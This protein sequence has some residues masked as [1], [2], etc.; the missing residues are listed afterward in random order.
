MACAQYKMF[1]NGQAATTQQLD[2][3]ETITVEQEMDHSWV[4][5]LEIPLCT[6][7]QGDWTGETESWLQPL[8]RLRIEL[9][10]GGSYVPLIDGSIVSANYDMHMEPGQSVLKLEV[11]DDG[12]LLHRDESV[13][14][15]AGITDAQIADRI[16]R[17]SPD[18]ATRDIDLDPVDA[19]SDLSDN[20][21]VLRGT[22]M[23]LL[24]KLAGRQHMQ[25]HA[26][27]LPGSQS[28]R[29]IGCFKKDPEGDSG[30]PPMVLL[31]KGRNV[32]NIHFANSASE[33]AVYRTRRVSLS[34]AKINSATANLSDLTRDGTDPPGGTAVK[35]L[36]RPGQSWSVDLDRSV[37]TASEEAAYALQADGEVLK[38]VY[39]AILTPY[40]NVQ[41]LGANG[42]QSG[43]WLIRQGSHTLTRNSYGQTFSLKRNAE[44]AGTGNSSPGIPASV[45]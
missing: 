32:V 39:C 11:Q 23:E 20:T 7:A 26:Y 2:S 34:D 41:V 19:P 36:L 4:A 33:P 5:H 29:S 37:L 35:R 16:F 1:L 17:H 9:S 14:L 24:Q 22:Q 43:L 3:F 28:H 6:N 27:V 30:L 45:F 13:H 42:R 8:S 40:Q 18:I 15:F 12:F 44:S 38:D 25:M 31:G 21:T 10:L